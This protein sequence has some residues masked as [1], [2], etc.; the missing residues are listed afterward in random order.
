MRDHDVREA[1]RARLLEEHASAPEGETLLVDELGVCGQGRVDLAVVNGS[2]TGYEVKS[3]RDRLDRLPNQVEAYGQVLDYAVLVVA[4]SHLVKA[5]QMLPSWWGIL[6]ATQGP[7]GVQVGHQRKARL[8]PAIQPASL[9]QLLWREEALAALTKFGLDRGVRSLPRHA[10][11]DR[12]ATHL[13]VD[14]LRAE[15]R[16]RLRARRGWRA[17]S[18]RPE[19]AATSQLSGTTSRFLARRV[20]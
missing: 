5:R 3:A 9:A 18:G 17:S 15:V 6:V 10:L 1:L 16:D 7:D 12:L 2:F 20:R 13:E 11:W 19:S 4:D 8:N 14:Q